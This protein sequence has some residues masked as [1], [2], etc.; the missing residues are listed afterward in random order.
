MSKVLPKGGSTCAEVQVTNTRLLIGWPL[1]SFLRGLIMSIYLK[2]PCLAV[3]LVLCSCSESEVEK[4][5]RL[6]ELF[7]KVA[8]ASDG[9][10]K[11]LLTELS[12][13]DLDAYVNLT[14][15][16]MAEARQN[17]NQISGITQSLMQKQTENPLK[18]DRLTAEC[19]SQTGQSSVGEGAMAVAECV[20]LNW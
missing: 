15:R 12:A 11:E 8:A 20:N 16:K 10:K 5:Q 14:G 13:E 17:L 1:V 19:E 3:A 7:V 4:Q 9:E 18:A 2:L 6:E